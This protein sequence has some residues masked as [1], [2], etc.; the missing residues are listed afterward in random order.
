MEGGKSMK[1]IKMSIQQA[2]ASAVAGLQT[3]IT[4]AT[5]RAD[6]AISGFRAAADELVA[7]NN[8]LLAVKGTLSTIKQQI[9]DQESSI[10]QQ[11]ADNSSVA[12]N[13]YALLTPK[14]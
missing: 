9:T 7:A 4:A 12:E 2:A 6:A 11:V 1:K 8:D 14:K 5:A 10:D 13:I 3:D